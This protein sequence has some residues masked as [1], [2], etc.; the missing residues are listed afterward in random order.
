MKKIFIS[1]LFSIAL[2]CN[3]NAQHVWRNDSLIVIG[4]NSTIFKY[5]IPFFE[6]NVITDSIIW[7][8]VDVYNVGNKKCNHK[9]IYSESKHIQ[10]YEGIGCLV[11]HNGFHCDWDDL[12]RNR[13]CEKC[14][15]KE[16]Q[17]EFWYEH[18]KKK[19]KTA[20]QMLD[21]KLKERKCVK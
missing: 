9:W 5:S 21:Q 4:G 11:L 7:K 6:N 17:R 13:I 14:L 18:I 8:T 19:A 1:L 10:S 12:I 3:L 20:Y 2:F 15:R 16:K